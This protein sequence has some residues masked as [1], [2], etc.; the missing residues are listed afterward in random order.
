M[1]KVTNGPPS[2]E[3]SFL[4]PALNIDRNPFFAP[5]FT[6]FLEV[7]F[8]TFLPPSSTASAPA[9]LNGFLN[10]F[11]NNCFPLVVCS[12]PVINCL[13]VLS[14][15]KIF[16]NIGL[17]KN[18]RNLLITDLPLLT[19]LSRIRPKVPTTPPPAAP[20]ATTAP[21]IPPATA[22][23]NTALAATASSFL[24]PSNAILSAPPK[25]T[26]PSDRVNLVNNPNVFLRPIV[27]AVIV[28]PIRTKPPVNMAPT[29]LIF[30]PFPS[31]KA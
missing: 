16:L 12:T 27:T 24:T 14:S 13:P 22:P 11:L 8:N 17:V 9:F 6:I 30:S 28:P 21:L 3:N 15:L 25:A 26:L 2:L 29:L 5:C 7:S 31:T 10:T 18:F 20:P 19:N 4:A 23:P 1:I